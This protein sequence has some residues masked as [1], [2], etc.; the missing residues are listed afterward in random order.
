MSRNIFPSA[1][2]VKPDLREHAACQCQYKD[3]RREILLIGCTEP[4]RVRD[5]LCPRPRIILGNKQFLT[6]RDNYDL[7]HDDDDDDS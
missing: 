2:Q 7:N 6:I 4:V 1:S 5:F 3:S